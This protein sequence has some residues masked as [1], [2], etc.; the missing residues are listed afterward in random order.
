DRHGV[1][2]EGLAHL[3]FDVDGNALRGLL[4]VLLTPASPQTS[5][6]RTLSAF[7][8]MDFRRGSTS[9]PISV[10]HVAA[11]SCASS[12]Y[13]GSSVRGSG[14]MVVSQSCAGFISPR[15]L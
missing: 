11:A 1:V 7:S 15:P 10:E 6:F 5:R 9:S 12:F 4:H 13:S 14:S 8:S 2:H 3:V